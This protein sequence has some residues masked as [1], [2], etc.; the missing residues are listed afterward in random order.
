MHITAAADQLLKHITAVEGI[1]APDRG[2]IA[3]LVRAGA[4]L[5]VSGIELDE[6]L[7]ATAHSL[8]LAADS[9]R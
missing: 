1:P 7:D 3:V 6:A 4:Q 8:G 2:V 5:L 9:V